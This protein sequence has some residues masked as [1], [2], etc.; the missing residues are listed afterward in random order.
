MATL[1]HLGQGLNPKTPDTFGLEMSVCVIPALMNP[2]DHCCQTE[3]IRAQHGLDCG[4]TAVPWH[5][6]PIL[7]TYF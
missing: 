1:Y 4:L 6:C 2:E 5:V 3:N 7:L